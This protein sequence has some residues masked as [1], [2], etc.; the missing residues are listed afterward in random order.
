MI[1]ISGVVK[2]DV[3]YSNIIKY[4]LHLTNTMADF[5][6]YNELPNHKSMF[7]EAVFP[8]L[9]D[10]GDIY[11]GIA[12]KSTGGGNSGELIYD[13]KNLGFIVGSKR[14]RRIGRC[15]RFLNDTRFNEWQSG[16]DAHHPGKKYTYSHELIDDDDVPEFVVKDKNGK[17]LAVNGYTTMPSDYE[18]ETLYY[19]Q[20]PTKDDRKARPMK[21][22]LQQHYAE[23]YDIDPN[24]G[25]PSEKFYEWRRKQMED[26]RSNKRIPSLTPVSIFQ[27]TFVYYE[28]HR[29]LKSA[30]EG[31]KGMSKFSK[32]KVKE[33]ESTIARNIVVKM[34]GDGQ[35]LMKYAMDIYNEYIREPI[36]EHVQSNNITWKGESYNVF[37][38]AREMFVKTKAFE[39]ARVRGGEAVQKAFVA[40]LFNR[41]EVKAMVAKRISTIL[42][43]D[44]NFYRTILEQTKT[45]IKGLILN[46]AQRIAGN[47]Q[48]P[49]KRPITPVTPP[50]VSFKPPPALPHDEDDE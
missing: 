48:I 16:L 31:L 20:N 42:K 1:D 35:W 14:N 26:K 23:H 37:N 29:Y 10:M 6:V 4:F 13:N 24:T 32:Q 30:A 33:L 47:S 22:W 18:L 34:G 15:E 45:F 41:P 5:D 19:T 46:S 25:L 8:E 44:T 11:G 9:D 12:P 40:Y 49:M 36:Y 28:Y 39:R 2:M 17:Y 50:A 7:K 38:K 3:I 21:Q 27:K 43:H